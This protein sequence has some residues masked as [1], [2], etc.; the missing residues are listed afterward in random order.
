M[1]TKPSTNHRH[2]DYIN[3][4]NRINETRSPRYYVVLNK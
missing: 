4:N 2:R 1:T 3:H